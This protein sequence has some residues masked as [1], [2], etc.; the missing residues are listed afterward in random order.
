[1]ITNNVDKLMSI[2]DRAF[3]DCVE[4]LED[5]LLFDAQD[6][7]LLNAYNSHHHIVSGTG[8]DGNI[9]DTGALHESM[10]AV[11]SAEGGVY[12]AIVGTDNDYAGWVHDGGW[13]EARPWISDALDNNKA[14]YQTLIEEVFQQAC[15][16]F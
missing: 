4:G 5:N 14:T 9:Y 3:T 6:Q 1:M 12:S 8:P 11:H 15:E 13:V 2:F 7:M 16:E 10:N